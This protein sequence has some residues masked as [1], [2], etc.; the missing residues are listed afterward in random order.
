MS[1]KEEL[2]SRLKDH[3]DGF[4][5]RKTEAAAN[6]QEIRKTLVAFANSVPQGRTAVFYI[7]V[8]DNGTVVGITSPESLQRT[9][10][11]QAKRVCYPPVEGY[12]VEVLSIDGKNVLAV[13]VEASNKRPHFAGPAYV[14]EGS[15][16]KVASDKLYEELIA[17]RNEKAGKILRSK[18]HPI[19]YR[20]YQVD[21]FGRRGILY[22]I[23]CLVEGCDAHVVY[24]HDA[25]G[26][27][28]HFSIPLERVTI[29]YDPFAYRVMLEAPHD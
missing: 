2:V 3:E 15:Q 4:L 24:L 25:A 28:R 22:A 13:S 14:R 5:E 6:A 7:G 10:A 21:R 9:I 11:D 1:T 19:T 16:S 29:N 23:E 20:P 18:G 17:G 27:G 26:S 12:Q 8:D